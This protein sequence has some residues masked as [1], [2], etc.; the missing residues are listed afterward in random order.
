MD[1][2]RVNP[3][4]ELQT[5]LFPPKQRNSRVRY[6]SFKV[7]VL[8][9]GETIISNK[10]LE[11]SIAENTLGQAFKRLGNA[12]KAKKIKELRRALV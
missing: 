7:D 3:M 2:V 12:L 11:I 9:N 6:F 4:P 10:S 1:G 5:P 8:E